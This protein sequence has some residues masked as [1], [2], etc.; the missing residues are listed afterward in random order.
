[1]WISYSKDTL[2][3]VEAAA[4]LRGVADGVAGEAAPNPANRSRQSWF[5]SP[6]F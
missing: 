3:D 6:C 5:H 1:M 2:Q 4:I